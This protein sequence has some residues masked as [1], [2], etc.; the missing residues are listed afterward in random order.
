M[1]IRLFNTLSRSVEVLKPLHGNEVTMYS[2]GPTVYDYAHVGNLRAILISDILHRTI[3]YAGYSIKHV[4]NITD[5]DD[6][7]IKRSHDEGL[8]LS[9]LTN[10]YESLFL[11]D[12]RY[13]NVKVPERLPHATK[14][15]GGMIALVEKLLRKEFA[16]ITDDGVYFDITKSVDY[17]A[18]AELDLSANTESRI[19]NDEYD[20]KNARDFALWKFESTDDYGNAYDASFGRGRPGWHI[21]CSAMAMSELGETIDIHTGGVDLVFPHHTN[22]IAQSEAVTGKPFVKYWLHNEFVMIDGQ[23]MSKS[24][25]NITTLKTIIDRGISSIAFR[26]W[27]LGTHYRAKA[28]FTWEGLLGAQTALGRLEDH[29]GEEIGA[30]HNDYQKRFTEFVTNDLDTP[31]ALALAWEVAKDPTLSPADKTATLLDFD[32]VLGLGLKIKQK[33]VIPENIKVLVHAREQARKEKNWADSDRIRDEI[34]TLGYDVL[35]TE[36]G[37]EIRRK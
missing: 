37:Q 23:K 14:H 27:V 13:L 36:K 11:A 22:E 21:E 17:G 7:T 6:K 16:Y 18:L 4:M 24:L 29:L 2:C 34:N 10:K 1:D 28:N 30:V 35:D 33:E 3:E 32:H 12:L 19:A 5:I 15:I 8:S 26:Y 9:E 25:G 31:Q 20:K